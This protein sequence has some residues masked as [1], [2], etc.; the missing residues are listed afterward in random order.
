[1]TSLSRVVD[2]VAEGIAERACVAEAGISITPF[3]AVGLV[4]C[5]AI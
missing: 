4:V 2:D 5:V 1:M 3:L